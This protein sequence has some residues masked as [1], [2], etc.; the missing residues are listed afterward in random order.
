MIKHATRAGWLLLATTVTGCGGAAS[1]PSPH[2]GAPL[3]VIVL[4]APSD[5]CAPCVLVGNDR[6]LAMAIADR[7][8][9]PVPGVSVRVQVFRVPPGQ[10]EAVALGPPVDAPYKG[11]LLQDKGV[12]V[13]HQGFDRAGIYK[14]V[15]RARKGSISA[16][17]EANFQVITTDPNVAVGTPAP[18]S[19]GPLQGQVSDISTIDTG[20]PPDDM[21]YITIA[22]AVAAHHPIVAFFG[23]PGFC[24]SKT[25]AP[26]VEVVKAL[27]AKYRA[28]G[29]DFVHVETYKGGRPDANHTVN[30]EF[31][32]WKLTTDPWVFVVDR[33]GVVSAKFDGPATLDEIEPFVAPLA[34]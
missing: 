18:L 26:E 3:Q 29:V 28:R 21:H 9:V 16:T 15:A 12:Y 10:A 4:S 32:Q 33:A 14:V 11:E 27:E 23:S 1:T 8:G 7:D 19:R 25:C 2:P 24:Q 20:V 5:Q 6:R 30:P 22:D 34:G 31:D 17:S 13:I